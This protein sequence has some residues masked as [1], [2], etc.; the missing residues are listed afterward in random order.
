MTVPRKPY[1]LGLTGG[2]GSGKSA[3][4]EVLGQLGASIVDT[5]VLAHRL[6]AAQGAAVSAIR[7][8]FGA[9]MVAAD[10]SLDRAAMRKQVFGDAAAR[11]RLEGILHPM[12]RSEA[13]REIAAAAGPYV[14]LVVPLLSEKSH[15]RMRC[16]RIAVVDCAEE[17]QIARV[18]QRSRLSET[19]VRAIMASQASRAER[20][21]LADDVIDN[22]ADFDSLRERVA[23]LHARC[24][25]AAQQKAAGAVL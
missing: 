25:A 14:V 22:D 16:D 17:T 20:R 7:E 13:E 10:G 11:S 15:W 5:D 21:A 12:I 23:A 4:S 8:A 3:V 24:I 1:V 9:Q 18:M 6:T 19:E 2:I